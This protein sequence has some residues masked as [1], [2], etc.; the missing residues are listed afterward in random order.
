MVL[1][2]ENGVDYFGTK[3]YGDATYGV[4]T[5]S[6]RTKKIAQLSGDGT[7]DAKVS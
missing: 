6:S 1:V 2:V 7:F 5:C 4:V 3:L